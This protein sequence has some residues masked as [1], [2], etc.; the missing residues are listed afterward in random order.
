MTD[1]HAQPEGPASWWST[2]AADVWAA[3]THGGGPVHSGAGSTPPGGAPPSQWQV[4][5]A[6]PGQ[7]QWQL[8]AESPVEPRPRVSYRRVVAALITVALLAGLLG[9]ALGVLMADRLRGGGGG[10][11][12]RPVDLGQAPP[13]PPLAEPAGSVAA[14]AKKVLPSVVSI[15]V[16]AGGS[17]DTGSG[18]I[19]SSDGYILTNNHVVASASDSG[20]I[21]VVFYPNKTLPAKIIGLDPQSDLAVIKVSGVTGLRKAD[22]GNSENLQVGDSVVA[23]GSPLGLTGTVTAG[24]VSAKD[25]P[26]STSGS[27]AA[28]TAVIDAIQTDAAINPGNSGGALVDATGA[29]VGINS[30]IA[31]LGASV[32]GGGQSGNIGVGFAIP[33]DSAR[34]ISSELIS[35]GHATHPLIGVQAVDVDA[36]RAKTIPGGVPGALVNT[37][38]AGGGAAK[39]GLHKGDLLTAVDGVRI[40]GVKELI[41][42]VRKH[43][44]GQVV[45]V[46]YV[47]GGKTVTAA[48]TLGSDRG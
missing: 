31:T 45:R 27:S 46:A 34:L 48:V 20:S 40:A 29:V 24:I 28:D 11:S 9:G 15:N 3:P 8:S 12:G 41:V 44:A 1:E 17:G 26:V 4:E 13:G 33:I 38:T 23:I 10:S 19:L 22:L 30:A 6:L 18:V 42:Q 36:D 47:R 2:P 39:A 5:P 16:S 37:V 7:P 14:I 35:T 25:R 32:F 43:R 21:A